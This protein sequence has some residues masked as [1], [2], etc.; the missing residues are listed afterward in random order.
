VARYSE[1]LAADPVDRSSAGR[2]G[3]FA[4]IVVQE[5]SEARCLRFEQRNHSLEH[6]DVLR[7]L[8]DLCAERI[9]GFVRRVAL[10]LV[11]QGGGALQHGDRWATAH[12]IR[13]HDVRL[14]RAEPEVTPV[15]ST[16][17]DRLFR[18]PLNPE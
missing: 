7:D 3:Q 18:S 12:R 11:G 8:L 4:L 13:G 17:Y 10:L 9:H 1:Q 5:F 15:Y 16:T 6:V 14:Y 2:V